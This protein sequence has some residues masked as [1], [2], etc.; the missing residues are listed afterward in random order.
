MQMPLFDL[1]FGRLSR[2]L[3]NSNKLKSPLLFNLI[4]Y[5]EM[6]VFFNYIGQVYLDLSIGEMVGP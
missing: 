5:A 1:N 3:V 2:Y 6:N 4:L